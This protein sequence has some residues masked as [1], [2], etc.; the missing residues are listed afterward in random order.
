[1]KTKG[2]K[3]TVR[4]ILNMMTK[5]STPKNFGPTVKE[6]DGAFE[7]LCQTEGIQVYCTMSE[8][9]AAFAERTKRSLKTILYHYIENYGYK[10]FHKLSHFVTTVKSRKNCSTDLC[11]KKCQE[12]RLS[13]H[14][15]QQVR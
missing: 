12:F 7:K 2:S 3:E 15:V 8:T 10:Y 6:F 5:K 4:A 13:V 11:N 1:M 9:K 14:Y